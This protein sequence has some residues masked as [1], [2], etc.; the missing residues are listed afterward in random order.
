V[1][2]LCQRAESED[3]DLAAVNAAWPTLPEALKAGIL[4]MVKAAS[5]LPRDAPG[6]WT[7]CRTGRRMMTNH[8]STAR[9]K[10][11][12]SVLVS[13]NI[14]EIP[15]ARMQKN[16]PKTRFQRSLD[17]KRCAQPES[18]QSRGVCPRLV[19][20]PVFKT[21]EGSGNRLLVGSIPIRSRHLHCEFL[22][23]E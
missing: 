12:H 16:A 19:P 17:S 22:G 21:G 13:C 2:A 4:A 8:T 5:G 11:N 9:G 7:N 3:P 14:P 20:G 1:S 15:K 18:V 10:V 6:N 23:T